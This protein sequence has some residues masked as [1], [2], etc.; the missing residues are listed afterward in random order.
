MFF[1]PV[2]FSLQTKIN[3]R[4]L[5]LANLWQTLFL[6]DQMLADD[7]SWPNFCQSSDYWS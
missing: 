4:F 6:L 1:L 7:I 3:C 2:V 5:S